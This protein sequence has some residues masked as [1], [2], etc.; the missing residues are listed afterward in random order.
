ME[1]IAMIFNMA[2]IFNNAFTFMTHITAT[3]CFLFSFITF[4]TKRSEIYNSK[5][6]AEIKQISLCFFA[7]CCKTSEMIQAIHCK[8]CYTS[9]ASIKITSNSSFYFFFFF[10]FQISRKPLQLVSSLNS[11]IPSTVPQESDISKFLTA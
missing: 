4:T 6:I 2:T 3:T 9:I 11:H 10:C 1:A 5:P 7:D 8:Y